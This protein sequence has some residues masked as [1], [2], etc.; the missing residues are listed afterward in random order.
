MAKPIITAAEIQAMWA[1]KTKN[2][3]ILPSETIVRQH[4]ALE[5][6]EYERAQLEKTVDELSNKLE[7]RKSLTAGI[8]EYLDE[9]LKRH[10]IKA[11]FEPLIEMATER[12]P[13]TAEPAIIRGTF[14]LD[15]DQRI[16][17]WT[18][19][20]SYQLPKLKAMEVSGQIDNSITVM[21][22]RF[23]GGDAVIERAASIPVESKVTPMKS[24]GGD[25]IVEKKRF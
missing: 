8:R 2:E 23:G 11:A 22:R 19:I 7:G 14:R 4:H 25:S 20:L 5:K 16:K 13:D 9:T 1:S 15:A 3:V 24:A 12:W 18:E 10:G 17:I 21:V 6:V